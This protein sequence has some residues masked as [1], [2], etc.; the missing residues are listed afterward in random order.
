MFSELVDMIIRRTNRPDM[1]EDI[2]AYLNEV[3]RMCHS[4]EYFFRDKVEVLLNTDYDRQNPSETFVWE[5]PSDMRS[6]TAIKFY[7]YYEDPRDAFPANIPPG[8]GQATR[9]QFYYGVGNDY[10]FFRRGGLHEIAISYVKAPRRFKYYEPNKRPA[11]YDRDF[12]TWKYLDARG[13]WVTSLGS[14]ELDK[15]AQLKVSDWLLK[16]YEG[17][18]CSGVMTK[19]FTMLGDPRNKVEYSNFKENLR[20]VRTAEKYE[21]TGEV[22]Y[23]R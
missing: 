7:G 21:S 15:D 9:A 20:Y 1:K 4:S 19:I 16:D 3:L 14:E 2:I 12:N 6:L 17:M 8:I 22:G 11:V 18:L 10:V 23:D 13:D 5:R